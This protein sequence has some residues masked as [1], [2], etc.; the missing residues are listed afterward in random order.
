[1]FFLSPINSIIS[2][3]EFLYLINLKYCRTKVELEIFMS[4]LVKNEFNIIMLQM[5][6]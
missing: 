2:T 5:Q 4:I 6:F 3:K 1:M